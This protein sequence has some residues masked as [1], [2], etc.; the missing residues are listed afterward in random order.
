MFE[1]TDD[2][3]KKLSRC[4][5]FTLNMGRGAN[6]KYKHYVFKE[7]G[8]A[9]TRIE[10]NKINSDMLSLEKQISDVAVILLLLENMVEFITKMEHTR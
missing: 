10:I 2:E 1:R 7:Q 8:T 5:N 6:I 4:K 3:V 9:N